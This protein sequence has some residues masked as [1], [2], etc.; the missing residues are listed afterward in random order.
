[1][2]PGLIIGLKFA[3]ILLLHFIA[4]WALQGKEMSRNKSVKFRVLLQHASIH[5]C[6]FG[7]GLLLITGPVNAAMFSLA[8]AAVHA[9]VDWF[10]WR[11]YKWSVI[12]RAHILIP[13]EKWAEW[14]VG[15]ALQLPVFLS[16]YSGAVKFLNASELGRK[17]MNYLLTEFKYW[18]DYLFGFMLGFD[19]LLHGICLAIIFGLILL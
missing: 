4:D 9:L 7:V 13:A 1:M 19:Q 14:N 16:G 12:L 11:S 2:T 5:L 6:V 3:Y 18:D 17:V 15:H 10:L 8:N